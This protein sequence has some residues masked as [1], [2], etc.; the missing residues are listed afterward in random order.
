MPKYDVVLLSDEIGEDFPT[1]LKAIEVIH[2]YSISRDCPEVFG[3]GDYY[4]NMV[5]ELLNMAEVDLGID[6]QEGQFVRTGAAL[7]D[8][9]LVNDNLHWLRQAGFKSVLDPYSKGL[10]GLLHAETHPEGR[11]DVVRDMYEALE[12]MAKIKSEPNRDLSS[13]AESFIKSVGASAGYREVLKAYIKYA[14][15][16]FRHATSEAQP[17]PQISMREA[18]SFVYLTG[19]FLRLAMPKAPEIDT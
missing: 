1:I 2:A 13:N 9:K 14:N 8:D 3:V 11:S 4:D 18:E 15:E 12:A 5:Q 6:W 7:L 19:V 16:Y 17:K 10:S